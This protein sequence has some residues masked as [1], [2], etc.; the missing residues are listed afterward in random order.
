MPKSPTK[1]PS[2]LLG[3]SF[4]ARR[5]GCS[6]Q[7]VQRAADTNKLPCQRDAYGRRLF[8]PADVDVWAANRNR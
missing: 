1:E 2:P 6:E 8:N 3:T 7:T 5:A 4:A